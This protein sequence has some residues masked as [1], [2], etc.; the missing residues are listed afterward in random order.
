MISAESV[1]ARLKNQASKIGH[2][3]QDLETLYIQNVYL[4]NNNK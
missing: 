2:I 3:L 1:K 4:F